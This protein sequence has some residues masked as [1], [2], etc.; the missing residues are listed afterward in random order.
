[1]DISGLEMSN[2]F[3]YF[4]K[5][6]AIVY[7]IFLSLLIFIFLINNELFSLLVCAFFIFVI[8]TVVMGVIV[9]NLIS[10]I[11]KKVSKLVDIVKKSFPSD[12]S[13][14]NLYSSTI[15]GNEIDI[16]CENV[17]KALFEL[18]ASEK[19]RNDYI[20]SMSHELRTPLTA[21]KGWAET[22]KTGD[23]IDFSTVR[24]GL[25]IIISEA[26]RLS[27]L[28]NDILDFSA[29]A[30]GRLDMHMDKMDI[31]AEVQDAINIC[32][33]KESIKNK[34]L[35]F[36]APKMS[37]VYGDKDRLKQVFINLIDNA[38]KYTEDD[39][40]INISILH[41]ENSVNV[42]IT[43]NGCGIK[44]SDLGKVT[45]K[46][47]KSNSNNGF[48]IGLSVVQD[49]IQAHKGRFQIMS[50]ENFGTTVTVSLKEY[51]EDKI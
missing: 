6:A 14:R 18:K 38:I 40:M 41:K 47:F 48:G 26:S 29:L 11:S 19:M 51:S 50:E 7:V 13:N 31:I 20:S 46:F 25:E 15:N 30:N 10:K 35:N 16:L 44:K 39:G 42:E 5:K 2:L 17:E 8:S 34:R 22:M 28:V 32:R 1:M 4:L 12:I 36:S 24:R 3:L 45:Q 27:S 23:S 49:I 9:F 33:E 21:I 37:F 43:D